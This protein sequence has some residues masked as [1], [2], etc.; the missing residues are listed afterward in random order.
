MNETGTYADYLQFYY[1]LNGGAEVLF[2]EK[3]SDIN[4]HSTTYTSVSVSGLSGTSLQIVIR[5]RAT[6]TDEFYYIDNV[7]ITGAAGSDLAATATAKR[8]FN[9]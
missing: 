3:R 6:G 4:N 2:A 1:K 9:L 7:K 8:P 5:A